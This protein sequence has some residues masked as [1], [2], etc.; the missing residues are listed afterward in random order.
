MF[1]NNVA[2]IEMGKLVVSVSDSKLVDEQLVIGDKAKFTIIDDHR[3]R[4][5]QERHL[6][7]SGTMTISMIRISTSDSAPTATAASLRSALF[8][9]GV[10]FMSQ[11]DLCSFGK[12]KWKLA[13]TG[14][15]E[16][17]LPN[18]VSDFASSTDLVTAAQK[19]LKAQLGTEVSKLGNKVMMCL[20]PGTGSWAASA[21]VNHWRAQ[22]NNDWCTSLSGIVHE[23]GHTMGLLHANAGGVDYA[24]RSG[25]MGSGYTN[26]PWPRK[27]FN[28]YNSWKLGWYGTRH[29]SHNPLTQGDR[30]VKLA[31]F[32]D[33]DKTAI[34]ES[35]V[36]NISDKYFLEYNRAK[37]FNIDT[38]HKKN[39][40]TVTESQAAGTS[41]LAGLSAGSQHKIDN[42]NGSGKSLIIVACKT[43]SGSKGSEVMAIS[44]AI[45]RSLCGTG[46]TRSNKSSTSSSGRST[47]LNWLKEKT[48]I[49]HN[50]DDSN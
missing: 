10:N 39:Q 24:D 13:D 6:Q 26:S 11:Y 43:M 22:F 18:R 30:L 41:S 1:A 36:I 46:F 8:S 44:I 49:S 9:G 19:Q 37:G 31:T 32:V 33:F 3:V 21:G 16:V 23:L 7:S 5:L 27:C 40:V 28:G 48:G 20:P 4:H 14:V 12:L 34:D 25:Y 38:E 15:I 42:F 17:K 47:V 29:L 35:V 45:G 50:K 2:D